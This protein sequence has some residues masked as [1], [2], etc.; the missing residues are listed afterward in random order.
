MS[1]RD[2]LAQLAAFRIQADDRARARDLDAIHTEL[3]RTRPPVVRRRWTMGVVVAMILAGPAA[4]IA[5][6]DALPG[7]VLY[8][9]KRVAEPVIQLFDRDAAVEHR[10]EEVAGLVNREADDA[11]IRERIDVA[12]DALTTIDSPALE[13]TLDG[14]VDR[15]IAD[16]TP[17]T[18][19]PTDRSPTTTQPVRIAPTGDRSDRE[20][21]PAPIDVPDSTTSTSEL[22]AVDEPSPADRTTTTVSGDVGE[23]PPPD[24][25]PRDSP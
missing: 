4:A 6:D 25:R 1:D 20:P 3:Q 8:P 23:R 24:D 18:D 19:R 15:W 16:R 13:R 14:I 11:L 10:V 21:D 17:T 22:P 7:D 2:P 5:A 12:R 9:I